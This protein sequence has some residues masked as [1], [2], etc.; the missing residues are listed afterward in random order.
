MTKI[1]ADGLATLES[2]PSLYDSYFLKQ[3]PH[4]FDQSHLGY[5]AI[6]GLGF[7]KDIEQKI[8]SLVSYLR[9][10]AKSIYEWHDHTPK[11]K[12]EFY[13]RPDALLWHIGE[14]QVYAGN[15][16]D[17]DKTFLFLTEFC[18]EERTRVVHATMAFVRNDRQ[19][20]DFFSQQPN[21]NS[22]MLE[23]LRR[24]WGKPL[25]VAHMDGIIE[26]PLP[27]VPEGWKPPTCFPHNSRVKLS[28]ETG[29]CDRPVRVS[30]LLDM[31]PKPNFEA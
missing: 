31:F 30:P 26:Q 11:P 12:V 18:D 20:F 2:Q 29:S 7:D 17:A 23:K 15:L 5:R 6:R 22:E 4:T 25:L 28:V 3:D 19:N 24:H 21:I 14:L 13:P 1:F 10:Y 27:M 9:C 8:A 16:S